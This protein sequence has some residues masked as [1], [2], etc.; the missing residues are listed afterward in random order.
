MRKAQYAKPIILR[1]IW[2]GVLHVCKIITT[3]QIPP[4]TKIGPGLRILHFGNIVV[5]PAT[6]IGKNFNIAQGVLIG[7]SEGGVKG[8]PIIGDNCCVFANSIIIG[9]VHIGNNV[10]IAPGAFV[11][12]DVPDNSIVIGNPGTIIP[13]ESSPTSKYILYD[14]DQMK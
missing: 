3:I 13:R 4:D 9:G 14:I 7:G 8:F 5:N 12:F 11:N 6:V 1:K 2:K 10:L